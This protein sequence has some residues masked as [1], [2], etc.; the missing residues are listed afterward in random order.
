MQHKIKLFAA[1]VVMACSASSYAEQQV[2]NGSFTTIK[3]VTI[4]ENTPLAL[5]GLGL[6]ATD[7]CTLTAGVTGADYLGDQALRLGSTEA[8][9]VGANTSAMADCGNTPAT[10]GV[11][12]VDGAS[13]ATVN[14]QIVNS[15]TTGD[16]SITLAGCAGDYDGGAD[17][18]DCTAV[19][20]GAAGNV[21][22]DIQLAGAGDTGGL[23]EG[24]PVD[25]TALI[26]LGGVAT[27]ENNLTAG[28]SYPV[29]FEINVSY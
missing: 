6:T 29:S 17:N 20:G 5:S 11:Y 7:T 19:T 18:D 9:A 21:G 27:A 2:L 13:G 3:A 15:V 8:N 14:I 26:A 23:G 24:T 28:T 22:T 25:G 12:E 1:L 4:T 10:I 16:V